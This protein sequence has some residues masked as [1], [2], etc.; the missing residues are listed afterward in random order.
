MG[1]DVKLKNDY[2]LPHISNNSEFQLKQSLPIL[3]NGQTKTH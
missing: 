3:G 1:V 2:A